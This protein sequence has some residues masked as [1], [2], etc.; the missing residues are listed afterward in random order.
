MS[1][2]SVVTMGQWSFR[3]DRESEKLFP[4]THFILKMAVSHEQ[5]P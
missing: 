2:Q 3:S 5:K 1:S 4:H